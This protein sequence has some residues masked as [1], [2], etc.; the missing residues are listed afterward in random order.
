MSQ[1]SQVKGVS[2]LINDSKTWAMFLHLSQLANFLVPVAGIVVPILIWQLKKNEM[3]ELDAH[4]KVVVNWMISAFIYGIGCVL[5]SFV[6]IGIPL[7][8]ALI[9]V[10]IIFPVIG[11]IKANNG[12]LWQYPLSLKL[13]K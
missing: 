10:A 3:P 2:K 1:L 6:F 8:F 7:L 12:E 4:G 5:L 13:I 9:A 11:G